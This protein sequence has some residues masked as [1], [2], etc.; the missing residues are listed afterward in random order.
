MRVSAM[1]P[2][3]I[4]PA[5]RLVSLSALTTLAL[6][7]AGVAG[8]FPARTST[9]EFVERFGGSPIK[10]LN[11]N[12]VAPAREMPVVTRPTLKAEATVIGD[13][14]RI[15]DLVE[16]AGEAADVAIFRAPDIGQTG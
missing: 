3:V 16:N 10:I 12:V 11:T 8:E 13:V 5:I 15:G 6:A 9:P 14:V 2:R 7:A 4:S 1:I